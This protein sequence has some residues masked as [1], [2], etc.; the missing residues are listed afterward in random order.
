MIGVATH[1]NI[2]FN[3]QLETIYQVPGVASSNGNGH[4]AVSIHMASVRANAPREPAA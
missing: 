2:E 1:H 3:V 4:D